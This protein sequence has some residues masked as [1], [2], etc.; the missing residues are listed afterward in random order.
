M[1]P[2][3]ILDLGCTVG[4]STL[5]LA[6]AFP[7]ADVHAIDV[8]A[9]VLRYGHARANARGVPVRFSQKNAEATDFPDAYFDVV[10]SAMFLHEVPQK[11]MRR[12]IR[13]VHRVLR[14]GGVMLHAEQPQY[15]GQPPYEHFIR[16]WDTWYN[17]EPFRCAF[18]SMDL[19]KLAV[20]GGFPAESVVK[21]MAPG[22]RKGVNGIEVASGGMW[23][24]YAATKAEPPTRAKSVL[25]KWGEIDE[26]REVG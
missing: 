14:P 3:R 15:H 6:Q 12:V 25:A 9:P 2:L 16:E 11:A 1:K 8:A 18:R 24:M 5:P 22:A 7:K 17:N 10:T 4:H 19:D 20:D 23:F 21:V 26:T 13:E